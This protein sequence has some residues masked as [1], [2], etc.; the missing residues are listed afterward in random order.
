[1]YLLRVCADVNHRTREVQVLEMVG[2]SGP[3]SMR[4]F[5]R[6]CYHLIQVMH[7]K[8]EHVPAGS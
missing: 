7:D 3:G 8:D 1:M 5:G 2:G 6:L 4:V